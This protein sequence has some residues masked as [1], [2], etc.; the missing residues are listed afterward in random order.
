MKLHQRQ[1][2]LL[3][4]CVV[5]W[6]YLRVCENLAKGATEPPEKARQLVNARRRRHVDA[7]HNLYELRQSGKK[8]N[9]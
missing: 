4:V 8:L 9:T 1:R 2:C 6:L 5:V 7:A 3:L